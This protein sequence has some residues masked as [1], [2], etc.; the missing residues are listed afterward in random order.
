[1]SSRD[2]A[3]TMLI[4]SAALLMAIALVLTLSR[5]GL[6]GLVVAAVLLA[7]L[8][9]R[10]AAVRRQGMAL[11]FVAAVLVLPITWVGVDT[12][13]SRFAARNMDG[14]DGRLGAWADAWRV[15]RAF[16]I[17][18]TG[19]NTYGTAMLF[20]QTS[21][22]VHH[23]D[24]AHSDYLQLAAEGG[25]LVALP[26]ATAFILLVIT[27]GARTRLVAEHASEYWIRMGAIAGLIAMA[28]QELTD[29]S[30]QI[31]ANAVL[32]AVVGGIALR[33]TDRREARANPELDRF[34]QPC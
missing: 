22:P 6:L 34:E 33:V 5:S 10:R 29:F 14:L 30:L 27:I 25:L 26:A 7:A 32:F 8:L 23:Y 9:L 19:L 16:P 15:A 31:P 24:A 20:Y 18:G 4:G 11:A 13:G 2:V 1:V 3:Q 21:D 17:A 28:V 12:L